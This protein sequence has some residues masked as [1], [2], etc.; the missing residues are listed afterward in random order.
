M[1]DN[2]DPEIQFNP[3]ND[4]HQELHQFPIHMQGQQDQRQ[5]DRRTKDGHMY[6]CFGT[7]RPSIVIKPD[8]FTGDE[9]REQ[10]FSH[11]EDCDELGR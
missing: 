4:D 10:Y 2:S 7:P 11:F 1:D 5:Y 3:G 9:D 8:S 6:C